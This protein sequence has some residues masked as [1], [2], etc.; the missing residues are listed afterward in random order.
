MEKVLQ[1]VAVFALMMLIINRFIKGREPRYRPYNYLT[2]LKPPLLAEVGQRLVTAVFGVGIAGVAGQVDA[3]L[4]DEARQLLF[5]YSAVGS[6]TI[7]RRK[8]E[9]GYREMQALAAPLD[10]TG[11]ALDTE[12][13]RLYLEAGGYLF[14]YGM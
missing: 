12:D 9:G 4:L 1:I 13:G 8:E 14:V 3:Y 7:Y 11:M 5:C 2:R 6:L 10:C